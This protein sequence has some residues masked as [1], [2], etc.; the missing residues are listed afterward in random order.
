MENTFRSKDLSE[1]AFLYAS[2][3]KLITTE[4]DKGKIWFIFEDKLSCEDLVNSFW[5]KEAS[6]NAK[7]YSDAIRTLK[8]LIFSR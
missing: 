1:A 5:S 2:H 6:I 8:D 3:K 4:N 7:E